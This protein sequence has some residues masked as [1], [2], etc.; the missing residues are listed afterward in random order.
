MTVTVLTAV[1]ILTLSTDPGFAPAVVTGLSDVELPPIVA[2][3][4]VGVALA[5]IEDNEVTAVVVHEPSASNP[6]TRA[7]ERRFPLLECI[8]VGWPV[9]F[10]ALRLRLADITAFG[11]GHND[12]VIAYGMDEVLALLAMT[13]RSALIEINAGINHGTLAVRNGCIVHAQM[14]SQTGQEAALRLLNLQAPRVRSS[15]LPDGNS[16]LHLPISA[17]LHE[18]ARRA[19]ELRSLASRA[20]VAA[21]LDPLSA[22]AED[23]GLLVADS[24]NTTALLERGPRRQS[25]TRRL[26]HAVSL[27]RDE[28]GGVACWD[29]QGSVTA[30]PFGGGR[31]LA[32]GCHMAG[33]FSEHRRLVIAAAR[34][35]AELV[36]LL[37][38]DAEASGVRACQ[39]WG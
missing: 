4:S 12:S 19:E 10:P 18:A 24:D 23:G 14:G 3:R 1:M 17:A 27:C 28:D 39:T 11:V 22:I 2:A 38:D 32:A 36:S 16:S 34:A 7:I 37:D 25:A 29:A 6:F 8:G 33:R 30:A 5:M 35:L 31:V 21:L 26:W 15:R 20:D 9:D 13:Q